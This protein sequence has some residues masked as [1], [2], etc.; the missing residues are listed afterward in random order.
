MAN[1]AAELIFPEAYFDCVREGI[2]LYGY[3]PVQTDLPFRRA[4]RWSTEVVHVKTIPAGT[5]VSYGRTFAASRDL[6]LATVAVGY[7]DGYH[8]AASNKGKML[9]RGQLADIVGRMCMDQTMIDVTDIPGVSAGDE[10]VLIGRQG[11]RVIDAEMLAAWC[12]TISYEVLL[13]VTARVP[14]RYID[15][16]VEKPDVF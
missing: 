2:S 16:T 13:A 3:P 8:R 11:E 15:S 4:L 6:R 14:R 12:G 7:G 5:T 1:S 9:V 10:V